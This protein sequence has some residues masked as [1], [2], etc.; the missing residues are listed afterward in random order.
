MGDPDIKLHQSSSFLEIQG[1][2][3]QTSK[4]SFSHLQPLYM[5]WLA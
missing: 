1:H 2:L 5:L 3:N 4:E